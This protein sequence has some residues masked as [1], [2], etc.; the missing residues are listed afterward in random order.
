MSDPDI[1]IFDG[2]PHRLYSVENPKTGEFDVF[3]APSG[4]TSVPLEPGW[5]FC[6][7]CDEEKLRPELEAKLNRWNAEW[8]RDYPEYFADDVEA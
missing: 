2:I 5:K 7:P 8:R 4:T 6:G 3:W 1:Q